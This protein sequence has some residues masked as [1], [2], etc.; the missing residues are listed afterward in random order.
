MLGDLTLTDGTEL[1]EHSGFNVYDGNFDVLVGVDWYHTNDNSNNPSVP[2]GYNPGSARGYP[3]GR[4]RLIAG[5]SGTGLNHMD[6]DTGLT[7]VIQN[8]NSFFGSFWLIWDGSTTPV[9]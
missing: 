4:S 6:T 5:R 3:K 2:S 9:L 8:S 7:K 1:F